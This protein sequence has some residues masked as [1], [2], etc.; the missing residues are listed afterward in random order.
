MPDS[1]P[2]DVIS[3]AQIHSFIW[4]TLRHDGAYLSVRSRP[5]G[6]LPTPSLLIQCLQVR[7]S[8]FFRL[9]VAS[10]QAQDGGADRNV[11]HMLQVSVTRFTR[12]SSRASWWPTPWACLRQLA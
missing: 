10:Y 1:G 3:L 11:R 9:L 6:L 12:G 2:A 4:P 8:R 7:R 5:A